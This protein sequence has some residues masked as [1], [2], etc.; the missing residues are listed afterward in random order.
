MQQ[1]IFAI[2]SRW[3]I[4][5]MNR[6]FLRNSCFHIT[7][8]VAELNMD[9][10][11]SYCFKL[12]IK[13]LSTFRHNCWNVLCQHIFWVNFGCVFVDL[14]LQM[15]RLVVKILNEMLGK[16]GFFTFNLCEFRFANQPNRKLSQN[17]DKMLEK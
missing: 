9:E 3:I 10:Q 6:T 14:I 12:L 7:T 4:F 8:S 15:E 16:K 2:T 13:P 5:K 17:F 1:W 11:Y